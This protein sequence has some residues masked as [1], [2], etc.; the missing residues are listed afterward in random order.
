VVLETGARFV[1]DDVLVIELVDGRPLSH[2]DHE[3][4]IVVQKDEN[5]KNEV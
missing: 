4:I 1:T 3:P 2:P 5:K